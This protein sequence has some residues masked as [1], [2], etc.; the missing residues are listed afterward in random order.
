MKLSFFALFMALCTCCFAQQSVLRVEPANVAKDVVVDDL[1]KD[2]Q[3]ITTITVTNTGSGTVQ[4]TKKQ[5]VIG[6]PRPWKYGTFS[7]GSPLVL[8]AANQESSRPVSLRPGASATFQVVLEPA[9]IAGDGRVEVQF[10]DLS[11]PGNMLGKATVTAE[12]IQRSGSSPSTSGQGGGNFSSRP[13]PTSVNLFPNPARERFFVEAPPG[14]KIGR[15]E[16]SN[17]LGNR[18][19]KY[20][21]P[22]GKQG[23]DVEDLPDGLYLISIYDDKGKKLKTLRLLHRQFGA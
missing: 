19:R 16:V 18:L 8:S 20:D 5:V 6:K 2:Y 12:I 4:L 22:D 13:V 11:N 9:G 14:T 1:D 10:F 15:V 17:A 23:Y 3:D 21:R 7:Q